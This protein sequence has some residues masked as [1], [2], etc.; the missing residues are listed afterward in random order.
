M[1]IGPL[2]TFSSTLLPCSHV[3]PLVFHHLG[4]SLSPTNRLPQRNFLYMMP[5][6]SYFQPIIRSRDPCF[7]PQLDILISSLGAHHTIITCQTRKTFLASLSLTLY[8]LLFLARI[9]SHK[10]RLLSPR[11]ISHQCVI[12]PIRNVHRI[13]RFL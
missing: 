10:I 5:I 1:L 11:I 13:L 4:L 9:N 3:V 12:F 2:P 7:F 6:P 8:G